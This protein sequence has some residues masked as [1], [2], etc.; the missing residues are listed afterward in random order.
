MGK[1][2]KYEWVDSEGP[3]DPPSHSH[4]WCPEWVETCA[5]D[6]NAWLLDYE[7]GLQRCLFQADMF[8]TEV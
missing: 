1:K 5:G 2:R 4:F 8:R 3:R 6:K 7:K